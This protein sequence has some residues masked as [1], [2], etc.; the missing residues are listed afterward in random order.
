MYIEI[1]KNILR[2][3]CGGDIKKAIADGWYL[4]WTPERIKHAFNFGNGTIADLKKH[5]KMNK[6][7]SVFLEV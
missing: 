2:D 5:M 4:E 6:N 3:D 7:Y 1:P